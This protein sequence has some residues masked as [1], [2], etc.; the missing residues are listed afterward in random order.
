MEE[1]EFPIILA[2]GLIAATPPPVLDLGAAALLRA[3]A[4]NHPDLFRVLAERRRT[5][6]AIELTDLPRRFLLQFG[7]GAPSLE[8][9][10]ARAT[11]A[12][13]SVK[14]SL[15]ALLALFEGR[16]DSDALFFTREIVVAGDTSAVVALRNI[17]D[18]EPISV[19][20]EAASLLGPLR[21]F[22]RAAALGWERR[23]KGLRGLLLPVRPAS[24][25]AAQAERDAASQSAVLR[26][27]IEALK[28]RLSK[29]EA[30]QRRKEGEAA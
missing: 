24:G 1:A 8:L 28:T 26:A 12:D 6:I 13:A 16:V 21:R 10:D 9:T 5:V 30:R 18:R 17:L 27:E 23:A 20:D 3:M 25:A 11:D 14:G 4:R 15:E 2:R 7:D 29:L 22:A 19:L